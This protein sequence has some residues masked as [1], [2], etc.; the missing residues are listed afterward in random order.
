L[1]NYNLT[2]LKALLAFAGLIIATVISLKLA[3]L[4][5]YV[6]Y[7]TQIGIFNY[8]CFLIL[9]ILFYSM[10]REFF[11]KKK[12]E[13]D[14]AKYVKRLNDVLIAQSHNEVFYTGNVSASATVLT[15]EAAHAVDADRASIW[16][17]SDDDESIICQQIYIRSEEQFHQGAELKRRECK[18]YFDALRKDPI[19]VA[20]DALTNPSTKCFLESYLKPLGIKS[21]L[22]V[23]I[24]YRGQVI[25]VICLETLTPRIWRKEEVNFSQLLSS[26]YSFAHSIKEGNQLT[27]NLSEMENFIDAAALISKTDRAG[28]ITYAN[29]KFAQVS[30]WSFEEVLGQDHKILNSG[31]HTKSFWKGMY[32]TTVDDRKIWNAVVTNRAKDGSLYYVDTYIKA[33]FNLDTGELEGFVSIRQDMTEIIRTLQE[34]GKKNTYLE[35]AA[36]I[37]RHDMNSGINIYVPRGIAALE[38]KLDADTISR[39]KLESPLK[40]VREGLK[41]AQKVYRG[42]YEFT[43]LVKKDILLTKTPCNVKVILEEYLSSTAYRSQVTLADNLPTLEVNDSL[44]CTA[45]DNLIRNGL[46]YND[47]NTKFV[48]IYYEKSRKQFGLSKEYIMVEDNGRGLDQKEFEQL[49][50]PYIRKKGQAEAGTGLGLNI[51]TAILNEH[52]F[53]ISAE[54]LRDGG[55]RLKIRIK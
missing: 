36:K 12:D 19:I 22:D 10:A 20:N 35:H 41:H 32:K 54:K 25:G 29:T 7:C 23:P 31:E 26:L 39:L 34:L 16:L 17:Y 13:L 3:I 33:D 50:K 8:S 2:K 4:L 55:T 48:K 28:K 15:K 11:Y 1:S 47:S 49:S 18:D 6:S 53:E 51:C 27:Q 5:E 40:M 9:S 46:K 30:G 14:R 21:M 43:N 42:V 44:F 52:G 45:I 24:W 38:R 37:L